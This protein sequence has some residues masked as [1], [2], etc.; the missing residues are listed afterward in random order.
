MTS[1]LRRSPRRGPHLSLV[2]NETE[3]DPQYAEGFFISD[4]ARKAN[5]AIDFTIRALGKV[6]ER[7]VLIVPGFGGIKPVYGDFRDAAAQALNSTTVSYRQP[8]SQ[9]KQS[10]IRRIDSA[11]HPD[12]L[13]KQSVVAMIDT[14]RER[15]PNNKVTLIGHSMGG[16]NAVEGALRR[17]DDVEDIVLLGAGGLEKGQN[18]LRLGK[19]M[20]GIARQEGGSIKNMPREDALSIAGQALFHMLRNPWRTAGEGMDIGNRDLMTDEL[21]TLRAHGIGIHAVQLEHDGFFPTDIAERDSAGLVDTFTVI[22]GLDH[23]GPQTH[24]EIVAN[25]IAAVLH[26]ARYTSEPMPLP[27]EA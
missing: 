12:K 8:R 5:A 2:T 1:P 21:R 6:T 27:L 26:A 10:I 24:P 18:V 11:L 15:L 25:H 14:M 7:S 20:P 13:G 17:L 9:N 4:R 23:V 19:R 16:P 3:I 22:K